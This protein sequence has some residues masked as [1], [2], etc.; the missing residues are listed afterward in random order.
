[1][2]RAFPAPGDDIAVGIDPHKDGFAGVENGLGD[3]LVGA[4]IG[5]VFEAI[6]GDGEGFADLCGKI[7]VRI[8]TVVESGAAD[9]GSFTGPKD[10]AAEGELF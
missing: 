4:A 7:V 1:M 9:L 3:A 8:A 6:G 5:F 10:A 2:L